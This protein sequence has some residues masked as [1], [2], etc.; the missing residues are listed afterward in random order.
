MLLA[1]LSLFFGLLGFLAANFHI[2]RL[3]ALFGL[4]GL[5]RVMFNLLIRFSPLLGFAFGVYGL[6][7]ERR[8]LARR[9]S[10]ETMCIIGMMASAIPFLFSM[11]FKF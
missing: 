5:I 4:P 2:A 3:L 7:R 1:V 10:V 11:G 9:E 6:V 8:G